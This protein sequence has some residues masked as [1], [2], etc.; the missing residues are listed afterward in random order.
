M[1]EE[2]MNNNPQQ[3]IEAVGKEQF[4]NVNEVNNA[5]LT[6]VTNLEN[7]GQVSPEEPQLAYN[8]P[9]LETTGE[10][11]EAPTLEPS[12][13]PINNEVNN[14]Q[15]PNNQ[16]FNDFVS[17]PVVNDEPEAAPQPFMAPESLPVQSVGS[18][19]TIPPKLE[20]TSQNKLLVPI[21]IAG[22][23]IVVLAVAGY[24]LA[25]YLF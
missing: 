13:L 16:V 17:N 3:P 20:T 15:Q 6:Q 7:S 10:A 5:N 1:P 19:P 21:L 18:D 12:V 4:N 24:F 25:K 14:N 22:I 11:P 23:V 9:S 2:P 8:A